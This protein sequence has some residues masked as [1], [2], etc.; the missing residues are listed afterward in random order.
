MNEYQLRII[1]ITF[2]QSAAAASLYLFSLR[3]GVVLL[4]GGACMAAGAYVAPFIGKWHEPGPVEVL[5]WSIVVGAA[6]AAAIA[7]TFMFKRD[8]DISMISLG[9][10]F[11]AV[12]TL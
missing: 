4:C 11:V 9:F 7:P 8:D 3:S 1:A 6:V 2:I 10:Q 5:S 12:A